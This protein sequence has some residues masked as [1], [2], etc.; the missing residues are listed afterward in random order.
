VSHVQGYDVLGTDYRFVISGLN[1]SERF[2]TDSLTDEIYPVTDMD[3]KNSH[4]VI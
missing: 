1:G 4:I 2:Y 3:D